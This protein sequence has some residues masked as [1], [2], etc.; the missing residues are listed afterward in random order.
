[1]FESASLITPESIGVDAAVACAV[2]Q[3]GP[4]RTANSTPHKTARGVMSMC[5]SSV[6]RLAVDN[7][8]RRRAPTHRS[9]AAPDSA[10]CSTAMLP[11]Q[12]LRRQLQLHARGHADDGS[13]GAV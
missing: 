12:R 3:R 4:A 8:N 5:R 7:E 9:V 13:S 6:S 2:A 11:Q 1:M 10:H